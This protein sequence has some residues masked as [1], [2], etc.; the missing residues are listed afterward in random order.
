MLE[1]T[2]TELNWQQDSLDIITGLAAANLHLDARTNRDIPGKGTCEKK[3]F[4]SDFTHDM[5]Q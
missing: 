4:H 3:Q 1:E 2:Q 5:F